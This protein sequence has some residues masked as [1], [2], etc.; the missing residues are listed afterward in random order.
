MTA[1]TLSALILT[2]CSGAKH[3][4]AE[5]P[6]PDPASL[7][8][9]TSPPSGQGAAG[10]VIA[11]LD[12]SVDPCV[13]F[14]A[15]ACGGW[16]A[17]TPLPPDR[18][19]AVRSFT[20]I[21]DRNEALVKTILEDAAKDPG[22][23]PALQKLGTFW[24]S[25]LDQAA[26]D[27]AGTAPLQPYFAKIDAL[28]DKR[29]VLGLAGELASLG[30][31]SLFGTWVDSDPKNPGLSIL[32]LLQGGTGLPERDYFFD[33]RQAELREQ[34][35]QHIG[36]MFELT[37]LPPADAA[38][39]AS[40]VLAF[41]TGLAKVEWKPAELRDA[42]KTYN[43]L[44]R[45]GLEKITPGLDWGAWL[46]GMGQ[47][48]LTQ[49]NVM[50]PSYFEGLAAQI[51]ASDLRV[52]QSYLK[53]RVLSAAAADL[54][55]PIEAEAFRFY[56]SI[57]Y[58]QQEQRP[59][60]KRCVERIDVSLGD[61]LGQAYVQKAFSGDSKPIALDMISRI[62]AAFVA[63]LPNLDWMDAETRARAAE[64]AGSITN[65]IGYP[66]TFRT[67]PY[68]V[69]AGDFFG[70]V[71]RAAQN[72]NYHWMSKAEKPA[73]PGQW[74]MPAQ[75]VNAYYNPSQNE[76]VFPAGILQPP[77]FSKDYPAA[78]NYGAMGMV[79]GH[80]ITHGFDDQGRKY[81]G[82]GRLT[83]WWAQ[84]AVQRFEEAAS[85]VDAQYSGYEIEPGIKL[86]GKLTLGEN[87]ADLGGSRL[88][89]QAYRKWVSERGEEPQF[90]G[91][92]GDQLFF[93]ALAQGWCSVAS[94]EFT[95]NNAAQDPHS[96]PRFRVNGPLTN[97]P[98][99]AAAFQCDIGDPMRPEQQCEI[100]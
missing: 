42:T 10:E 22:S 79:M 90:A 93:V 21:T 89:Y 38:A 64:K 37:G 63:G 49:I 60:W 48:S 44:D 5:L 70:N 94:P 75:A 14:Y 56:G 65:K 33:E 69:L 23:D 61:L 66:D 25:C 15:F 36:K 98:E 30:F 29:A 85:C 40:D 12:T 73:D 19:I 100:W 84:D 59:R 72:E 46:T 45:K 18:P 92:T 54:A 32:H 52:I 1:R 95:R 83:D 20:S 58:G 28:K 67:Y 8:L 6:A 26:I 47:P 55:A 24:S 62:E 86:D 27:A 53:W 7:A 96:P 31:G 9:A 3:P 81:D 34:Y 13:D 68:E 82:E 78:M 87:I 88:A 4:P 43:K 16:I 91:F 57:L 50:T 97:S 80:E 74:F 35:K 71:R 11:S 77:F 17:A 2:A 51:K 76:I 41:E 39:I 99:F